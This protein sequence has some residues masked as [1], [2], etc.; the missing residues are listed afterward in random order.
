MQMLQ[1]KMKMIKQI[2]CLLLYE[3]QIYHPAKGHQFKMSL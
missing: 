1:Q 3:W 2:V